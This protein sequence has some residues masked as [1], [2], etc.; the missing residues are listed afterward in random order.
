MP[1]FEVRDAGILSAALAQPYQRFAGGGLYPTVLAKGA[2]LFRGLIK[3]HPLIDGNKRVAVTT[4]ATFLL[5]NGYRLT[6][7]NDQ[8][9]DYALRIAR[10]HGEYPVAAILRWLGRH[11]ELQ[12]DTD[13]ARQRAFNRR[14]HQAADPIETWFRD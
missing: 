7:T 14:I 13:L 3:N 2:C 9:R 10:H 11:S 12:S 6:A 5:M 4:L 1:P 8:M